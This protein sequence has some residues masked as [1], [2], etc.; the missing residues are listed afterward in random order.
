MSHETC[1]PVTKLIINKNTNCKWKFKIWIGEGEFGSVR[2]ACCN[3]DCK[4]V[5]KYVPFN[6]RTT[7][8]LFKKE[9]YNLDKCSKTP[10]LCVPV[11]TSWTCE[12]GG[13]IIMPTMWATAEKLFF[14]FPSLQVRSQIVWHVMG[15][16]YAL[17]HK[18]KI[19]HGDA[20]LH[21]V[22]VRW[23]RDAEEDEYSS[24]EDEYLEMGYEY[25]FIDLG[26]SLD[27]ENLIEPLSDEERIRY[28]TENIPEN[29]EQAISS[30]YHILVTYLI[31]LNVGGNLKKYNSDENPEQVQQH[32]KFI[33]E[34]LKTY[35]KARV[36]R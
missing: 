29:P 21:N 18:A 31:E 5:A 28:I 30:D 32:I 23:N 16:L 13:I 7:E 26:F 4:W 24:S 15:M 27:L 17:H 19:Y 9:V 14:S 35:L 36:S 34:N 2:E 1:F 11:T 3:G 12:T 22:M 6:D 10:K 33:V 8:E 20:Q 25:R